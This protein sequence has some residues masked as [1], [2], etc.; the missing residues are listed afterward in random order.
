MDNKGDGLALKDIDLSYIS[1]F[2]QGELEPLLDIMEASGKVTVLSNDNDQ[3]CVIRWK[4]PS[5]W[6]AS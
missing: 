3:V 4:S 2:D 5:D 6:Y 1:L